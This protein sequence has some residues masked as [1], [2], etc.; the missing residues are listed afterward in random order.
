M[1]Y[2]FRFGQIGRIALHSLRTFFTPKSFALMPYISELY[3]ECF[4]AENSLVSA[5]FCNILMMD[6]ASKSIGFQLMARLP[7]ESTGQDPKA[8][9]LRCDPNNSGLYGKCTKRNFQK[10]RRRTVESGRTRWKK[11]Q[12]VQRVAIRVSCSLNADF[13]YCAHNL[14]PKGTKS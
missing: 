4:S 14:Y 1:S 9:S 7:T 8:G 2:F 13:G 6:S 11:T 10:I 12:N 5:R 3:L